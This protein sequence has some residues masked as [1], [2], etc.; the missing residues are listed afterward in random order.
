VPVNRKR[1]PKTSFYRFYRTE[2]PEFIVAAAQDRP[3]FFFL[4]TQKK[5][6]FYSELGLGGSRMMS[7]K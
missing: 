4:V 7:Y 1:T 6:F 5:S 3:A 2:S